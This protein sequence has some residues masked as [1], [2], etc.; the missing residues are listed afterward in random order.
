MIQHAWVVD[1]EGGIIETTPAF[2]K[3]DYGLYLGV[4]FTADFVKRAADSLRQGGPIL[5]VPQEFA[6]RG[7]LS[8]NE[9]VRIDLLAHGD[10]FHGATRVAA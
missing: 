9:T 5:H 7:W 1:P 6:K 2:V 10:R 8:I 3:R 4:P